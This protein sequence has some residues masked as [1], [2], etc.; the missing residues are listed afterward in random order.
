MTAHAQSPFMLILISINYSTLLT[1]DY[2]NQEFLLSFDV[3]LL[4]SLR[5][6]LDKKHF[7]NLGYRKSLRVLGTRSYKFWV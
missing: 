4:N 7:D 1:V 6:Q 2:K 5:G 3:G